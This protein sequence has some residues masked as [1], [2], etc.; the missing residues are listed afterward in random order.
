MSEEKAVILSKIE[1]IGIDYSLGS[2]HRK[3]PFET[4]TR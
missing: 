3:K 4:L 2:L 1:K